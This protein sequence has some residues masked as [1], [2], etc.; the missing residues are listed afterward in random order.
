MLAQAT[1]AAQCLAAEYADREARAE[2][3][4][5]LEREANAEPG[6]TAQAEASYE[7]DIE[8]SVRHEAPGQ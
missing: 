4:A 6:H 5:R 2:Y 3:A 8:L 7:A 1:E